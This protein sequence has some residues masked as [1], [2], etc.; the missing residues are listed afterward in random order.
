ME[1]GQGS[2]SRRGK[3][4]VNDRVRRWLS[5][6]YPT[7]ARTLKRVPTESRRH[8]AIHPHSKT[9]SMMLAVCKNITLKI[10]QIQ[11]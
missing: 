5:R 10:T 8:C 3:A 11:S 9:I 6:A 1:C 4:V 2:A 7:L